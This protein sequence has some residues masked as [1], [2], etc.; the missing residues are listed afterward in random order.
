MTQTRCFSAFAAFVFA[1][2]LA[3]CGGSDS[4]TP[5]LNSAF[6]GM[7]TGTT[8]LTAQ[9]YTPLHYNGYMTVS[10]SG[11]TATVTRICYDNSGAIN[12]SG[13][14][15]VAAWTGSLT[16][17]PVSITGLCGSV[18]FTWTSAAAS[19]S[20][21]GA[22]LTAQASGTGTGCGSTLPPTMSFVAMKLAGHAGRGAGLR[23]GA[24]LRSWYRIDPS[25]RRRRSAVSEGAG[26]VSHAV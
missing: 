6:S 5:S 15:N 4:P 16:C 26:S 13:S 17:P 7:W 20:A 9:G 25:P 24:F 12:A 14:G 1:L 18:A 8:T 10:A 22:T 23:A 3:A 11:Q 19:L 21:D 2:T